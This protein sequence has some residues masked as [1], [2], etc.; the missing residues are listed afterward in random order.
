M[1]TR[2]FEELQERA[3]SLLEQLQSLR[4]LT[5]SLEEA[6]AAVGGG[7][8]PDVKLP[9]IRLVVT[10]QNYPV[11]R[12]DEYLRGRKIP[13]IGL[14]DRGR[15]LLDLRSILECDISELLNALQ[16]ADDI[17]VTALS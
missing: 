7:A 12:L 13:I 6:Y 11:E 14:L 1:L 17:L 16:D 15:L 10:P 2:S 8:L 3:Q 4:T 9:T 5:L